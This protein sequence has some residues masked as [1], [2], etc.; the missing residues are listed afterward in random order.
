MSLSPDIKRELLDAMKQ[1]CLDGN[2]DATLRDKD[3]DGFVLILNYGS[4]IELVNGPLKELLSG[5]SGTVSISGRNGFNIK[6]TA[7]K[8]NEVIKKYNLL[9]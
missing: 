1:D 8:T 4:S 7:A 6:K 3:S 5:H 2:V 9:Q